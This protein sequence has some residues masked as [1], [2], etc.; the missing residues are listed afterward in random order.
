MGKDKPDITSDE[1]SPPHSDEEVSVPM[2]KRDPIDEKQIKY[3]EGDTFALSEVVERVA[4]NY[5]L[6]K[7]DKGWKTTTLMTIR[8]L[9]VIYGDIGTSPLYVISSIF[10]TGIEISEETVIGACSLIVWSLVMVVTFKYIGLVLREDNHGEGGIFALLSLLPPVNPKYKNFFIAVALIGSSFVI[11]DGCIT[12]A[13]SVLSAIEGIE[14]QASGLSKYVV[15]VTIIILLLLFMVQ[16]FGTSKIGGSFGPVMLVW[17]F[18]CAIYGI[19]EIAQH[20][21]ILAAFSPHYGFKFLFSGKGGFTVLSTVVLCVTGVE[22]LYADL[23]HFG[24]LPIR[25]SWLSIVFPALLL[26]YLGQGAH[27]IRHPEDLSNLFY[28]SVPKALFWPELI[29]A[30]F[31]T[32]IA[33]QAMISGVFSLINQAVSFQFF[34]NVKIVHTSKHQ[35]G[36]IYIPELNYFV[37]VLT[38]VIVAAFQTSTTISNAYGV[39]VTAVMFL[40]SVMYIAVL[41][42]KKKTAWWKITLYVIVF[43][44]IDLSFFGTC[45]LKIPEGGW[46]PLLIGVLFATVMWVWKLGREAVE[47][48]N[49]ST[50]LSYGSLKTLLHKYQV[51]RVPSTGVFLSSRY[52]QT[53]QSISVLL[54]CTRSLPSPTIFLTVKYVPV[55]YVA[56]IDRIAM[57]FVP[58]LEG[59]TYAVVL[60][61]FAE[62]P[63]VSQVVQQIINT[64]QLPGGKDSPRNSLDLLT[65]PIKYYLSRERIVPNSNRWVG[66]KIWVK[67]YEFLLMNSRSKADVFTI[68]PQEIVDIGYMVVL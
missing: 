38:I 15:I 51:N 2:D 50:A 64:K 60:Y 65:P 6:A 14:T 66:H 41:V 13:I 20:P 3:I 49:Q 8:S 48:A 28:L 54:P 55:P 26:N 32:V 59:V 37:M 31:A 16:H 53:P 27:L 34:P 68:A 30:T 1:I 29:L 45:L 46:V 58:E 67:L 22:A 56:E 33:S 47:E 11:G 40:T 62:V 35:F 52:D 7:A 17:F 43:C 19:I 63:N 5:P 44:T 18:T 39:A 36:Q 21:G 4:T 61:G 23:G 24:R 42:L 9:G 25:I 57:H 10:G 12:P